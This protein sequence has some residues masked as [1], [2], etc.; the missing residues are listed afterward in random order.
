VTCVAQVDALQTSGLVDSTLRALADEWRAAVGEVHRDRRILTQR[1][2]VAE[3][4]VHGKAAY[5]DRAEIDTL[6]RW[7]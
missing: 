5:A 7:V 2:R 3:L 6:Q 4:L 1:D